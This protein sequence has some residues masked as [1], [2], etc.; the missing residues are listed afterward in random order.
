MVFCISLLYNWIQLT[1]STNTESTILDCIGRC[2]KGNKAK[3]GDCY[4]FMGTDV[5]SRVEDVVDD[6]GEEN[7]Q[8]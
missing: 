4:I 3:M 7:P 1:D 6:A 2:S 5:S 8:V